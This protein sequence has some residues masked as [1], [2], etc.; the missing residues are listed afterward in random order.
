MIKFKVLL[1]FVLIQ[2][3]TL[4]SNESKNNRLESDIDNS[5]NDFHSKPH[6]L[7]MNNEKLQ[8]WDDNMPNKEDEQIYDA[9]K[10]KLKMK[11]SNMLTLEEKKQKLESKILELQIEIEN[12]N[13]FEAKCDNAEYSNTY[14]KNELKS[15][16]NKLQSTENMLQSTRNKLEYTTNEVACLDAVKEKL[17]IKENDMLKLQEEKQKLKSN[18][19]ELQIEI[20]DQEILKAR[21]ENAESYIKNLEA[22]LSAINSRAPHR[23]FKKVSQRLR[24]KNKLL[25]KAL[26]KEKGK[27]STATRANLLRNE[28][29]FNSD[30]DQEN[31]NYVILADVM[32]SSDKTDLYWED[33]QTVQSDSFSTK[34]S[35]TS[36]SDEENPE[37]RN[38]KDSQ[39]IQSDSFSTKEIST[40]MSNEELETKFWKAIE[41]NNIPDLEDVYQQGFT[42]LYVVTKY[43]QHFPAERAVIENHI[44]V[45]KWLAEK[46]VD[47]DKQGFPA[48]K[49]VFFNRVEIFK[50]F[51]DQKVDMDRS[52]CGETPMYHAVR[53][54]N[55][56]LIKLLAEKNVD[57]L[58]KKSS[59]M[60]STPAFVASL[61]GKPNVLE[62]LKNNY[63]DMKATGAY[64]KLSNY[65]HVAAISGKANVLK[66]LDEEGVDLEA[67]DDQGKTPAHKAA[68][69]EDGSKNRAGSNK[70]IE[71]FEFL[72]NKGVDLNTEDHQG[73]T[74]AHLAASRGLIEI[75]KF[76]DKKDVDLKKK[77]N[78]E[79][80]LAH[81]AMRAGY[82][83]K[84]WRVL[85]VLE[86]L[87]KKG[88]DLNVKDSH[89][90]TVA[91]IAADKGDTKVLRFLNRRN[92]FNGILAMNERKNQERKRESFGILKSM[93]KQKETD[94]LKNT[95]YEVP[96]SKGYMES[97]KNWIWNY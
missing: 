92:K 73:D 27:R 38:N 41:T 65:A 78:E 59:G 80:T 76:L 25:K 32:N 55:I 12:Q 44:E 1:I 51:I 82:A 53:L 7:S 93:I 62:F 79:E 17:D 88:V 42:N 89:G 14:L 47:F 26:N 45:L 75:L 8:N 63:I 13:N 84:K 94:K 5:N 95:D 61:Y 52:W 10:E 16:S 70:I 54:G 20:G 64:G 69:A 22:E 29:E 85:A 4:A 96:E 9:L 15:T 36:T 90:Q 28:S 33:S 23:K 31:N 68:E 24:E 58:S 56:P 21:N 81:K 39:T 71:V 48:H 87:N 57:Y 43:F 49:A 3:V 30:E 66:F 60:R 77:N 86:F 74:P 11:E 18:I 46:S 50:Y 35:S 83:V 72:N 91:D 6:L 97:F 19:L 2:S 34:E 40:S 67:K 37:T